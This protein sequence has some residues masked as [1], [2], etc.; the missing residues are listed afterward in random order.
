MK[1]F[2]A[3]MAL[4]EREAHRRAATTMKNL[5]ANRLNPPDIRV[6]RIT[7]ED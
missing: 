5:G 3:L 6:L 7:A 1:D 2:D 4:P